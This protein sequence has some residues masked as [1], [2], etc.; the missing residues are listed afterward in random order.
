VSDEIPAALAAARDGFLT[1]LQIERDASDNTVEAYARDLERYL[2]H[3]AR[4]GVDSLAAVR[5]RDVTA[6]LEALHDFGLAARSRARTL[7]AVRGLHRWAC[8]AGLCDED[9]S[10][11]VSGPRLPRGLPRALR[12]DEI[13][14]LLGAIDPAHALAPRDRAL[15]ELMYSCGLRASEVCALGVE[16]LDAG[17][18]LLRVVG[19]GDKER[20]VPV[21]LPALAAVV[22]YRDGLRPRLVAGRTE[23]ALFVNARGGRLSRMGLWKILRR[24]ATPAG[25]ADRVTP[26]VLRHCFATHLLQG[27]ADLRAVQELLGHA[28][29]RTTQVYT[30]LEREHLIRLHRDHHPRAAAPTAP[31]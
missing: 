4:S 14:R 1:G 31:R 10:R 9:P 11:E 8:E 26:H 28:D 13:D 23:G 27:G 25:L 20:Q 19:K 3:L 5:P 16:A 24:W 30:R 17:E 6:F 29:I 15:L 12:P 7:S 21:G 18:A 22:D 2:D